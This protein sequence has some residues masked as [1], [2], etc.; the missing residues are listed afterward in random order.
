MIE[1][2]VIVPCY[3]VEEY[4]DRCIE[5]IICQTVNT[6][7]L[8]IICVDDCSTD[9]TLLHLKEWERKYSDRIVLVECEQ[10][11]H[12]GTARNIGTEYARGNYIAFID[13]DDWIEPDYFE[14]LLSHAKHGD[15]DVV[16]CNHVR[17]NN[18]KLVYL[19]NEEKGIF[20]SGDEY[21]IDSIDKRKNFF[22]RQP[23]RLY[24]WGKLIK[25]SFLKENS[26][27]FPEHLAYEDVIWGNNIYMYAN[28]CLALACKLYHYYI[29]QDSLVLKQD[30]MHHIDHFTVNELMWKDWTER[31]LFE[32]YADELIYEY[33]FDAYLATL[34][35]LVYRFAEAPYSLYRLL[36]ETVREKIPKSVYCRYRKD[37]T[38]SEFYNMLIDMAYSDINK[39]QF[40]QM[41]INIKEIGL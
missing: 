6:N 36:Q 27:N 29:K 26:I 39:E 20:A 19:D 28:K 21:I 30:S 41:V 23:L 22:I 1:I 32:N 37:G 35:I 31:Q 40:E 38:I 34:K 14:I 18:I 3:N 11:G 10:N 4:I 33:Y 2:S 5:S 17:D 8:E 12:L 25:L 9:N 24:A 7:I 16:S 15:Y 13:S